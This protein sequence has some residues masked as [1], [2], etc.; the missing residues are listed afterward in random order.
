MRVYSYK[1]LIRTFIFVL[2]FLLLYSDV[3][4]NYKPSLF[5]YLAWFIL[6]LRGLYRSC[7][8]KGFSDY[9]SNKNIYD[10]TLFRKYG[11]YG[12]PIVIMQYVLVVFGVITASTYN[13]FGLIILILSGVYVVFVRISL[14]KTF[15]EVKRTYFK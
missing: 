4:L 2:I 1:I 9:E 5:E 8:E 6:I 7:T 10:I 12:K 13:W 15:T 11:K 3:F 14:Q